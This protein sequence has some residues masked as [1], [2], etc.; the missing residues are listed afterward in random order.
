M[1][2]KQGTVQKTGWRGKTPEEFAQTEAIKVNVGDAESAQRRLRGLLD[3]TRWIGTGDNE[4]LRR[5]SAKTE[6]LKHQMREAEMSRLNREI[7]LARGEER[8]SRDFYEGAL[9]RVGEDTSPDIQDLQDSRMDIARQGFGAEAFR[10]AREARLSGLQREQQQQE[11]RL[12]SQ[13]ASSGVFGGLAGAQRLALADQ[14]MRARQDAE[15]SLFLD[16]VGQRQ[17]ALGL[18][19]DTVRTTEADSLSRQKYNQAQRKAEIMG[20]LT[21]QYGEAALGVAERS[22]ARSAQAANEYSQAMARQGGGKK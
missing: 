3:D 9:G 2:K 18:A 4:G 1:V 17:Q 16:E 11:R 20:R 22:S 21:G 15:R 14:Q 19:E 6:E 10:A 13:L 7:D 5:D 8:A 12:G